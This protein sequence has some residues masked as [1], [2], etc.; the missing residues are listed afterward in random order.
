MAKKSLISLDVGTSSI[1]LAITD[2]VSGGKTPR[3]LALIKKDS[4]GLRR[5][6]IMNFDETVASISEAVAEA[7]RVTKERIRGVVLGV[8]GLTLEAKSADGSAAV[9]RADQEITDMDVTRAIEAAEAQATDITNRRIIHTIP[10]AFKL[11]GKKILGRPQGLKGNKLEVKVLFITLLNQHLNDLIKAVEKAGLDVEDIV[12][13]PLAASF[14]VLTRLQKTAGCA[15][16]NIGA[17]TTTLVT[18]E[19]GI[20]ISLQVFPIGSTDITND[21]A[22]G[23][24]ISLE[25]AEQM[26]VGI[27]DPGPQRKKFYEII[28]ARLSDI[29]ELIEGHLKKIGRNGLLPAGVSIIG[30]GAHIEIIEE[31]AKEYL[32]LPAQVATVNLEANSKGQVKDPAWAVAYG[33]CLFGA[34][35]E[36]EE[37]IGITA[38]FTRSGNPVLKWLKQLW[39]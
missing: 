20:P 21:I 32:K 2:A 6:Y 38:G 9:A 34:D 1:R 14:A 18:L 33:L 22:L 19:E 10:L 8:G 35:Q 3:V 25:E 15:L 4:K 5:G 31:V 7:E 26:K 17:Q 12:A 28:E 29:F 13:S 23:L 16:V 39:P 30:G 27:L 37:T 11:D 24:K 36:A